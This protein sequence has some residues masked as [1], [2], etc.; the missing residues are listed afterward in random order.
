[1]INYEAS[2][3]EIFNTHEKY[4]IHDIHNGKLP[5]TILKIIL[6]TFIY[7]LLRYY[8]HN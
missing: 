2:R 5:K 6:K 7:F 4:V 8:L 1:M 3:N